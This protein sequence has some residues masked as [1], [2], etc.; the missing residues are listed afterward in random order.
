MVRAAE[1]VSDDSV[2]VVT[3]RWRIDQWFKHTPLDGFRVIHLAT[4]A[5][6]D[7]SSLA[8]TAL[9]LA[10]GGGE[11]GFLSPPTSRASISRQSW[12]C[13]PPAVPQAGYR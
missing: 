10:P 5:L 3:A 7:E 4:H 6:I 11:D 12:S 2:A 1:A 8:R 13:F 9:T